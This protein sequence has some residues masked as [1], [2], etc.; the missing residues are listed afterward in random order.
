MNSRKKVDLKEGKKQNRCCLES[1]ARLV[2][3]IA[4]RPQRRR[5]GIPEALKKEN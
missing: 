2:K 4:A 1:L 3:P 5:N